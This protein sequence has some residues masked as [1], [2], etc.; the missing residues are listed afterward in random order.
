MKTRTVTIT[1]DNRQVAAA[2]GE[3]I[4]DVAR[5]HEIWIPTLCFLSLIH[6]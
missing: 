1:I 6:I 2:P 4:L 3:T 5:R